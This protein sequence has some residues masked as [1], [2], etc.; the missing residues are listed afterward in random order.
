[1]VWSLLG[2]ELKNKERLKLESLFKVVFK[3]NVNINLLSVVRT[4][5]QVIY[6]ENNTN[7]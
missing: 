2:D 6:Q 5:N 3:L 7:E 4:F 1:M